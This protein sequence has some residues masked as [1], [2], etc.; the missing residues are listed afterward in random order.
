MTT[1]ISK[2]SGTGIEQRKYPAGYSIEIEAEFPVAFDGRFASEHGF[3]M[4]GDGSLRNFG[5]EFVSSGP[6]SLLTLKKNIKNLLSESVFDSYIDTT[7]TSTHIHVNVQ[8]MNKD[9][10]FK[11]LMIYYIVEPLLFNFCG[12]TRKSNLF[13]LGMWE[14]EANKET[15]YNLYKEDFYKVRKEF[16]QYK[17]AALNIGNVAKIGTIE[18]RHMFGTKN[19]KILFKW[20]DI[21]DK[22]CNSHKLFESLDQIWDMYINNRYRFLQIILDGLLEIPYNY[23]EETDLNYSTVYEFLDLEERFKRERKTNKPKYVFYSELEIDSNV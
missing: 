20:L 4:I 17:Y 16:D 13:C 5:V 22:I 18:F 7:R 15:I 2:I 21:V 9:E 19:E 10:L 6:S 12:P 11:T 14:A 8:N 3:R 23:L 1:M